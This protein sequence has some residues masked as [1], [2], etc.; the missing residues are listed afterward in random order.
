MKIGV[1]VHSQSVKNFKNSSQD[2][3]KFKEKHFQNL[4][5]FKIK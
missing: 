5:Y 3:L 1:M 4:L 2:D